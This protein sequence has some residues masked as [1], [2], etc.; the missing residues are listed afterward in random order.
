MQ[1]NLILLGGSLIQRYIVVSK[2]SIEEMIKHGGYYMNKSFNII[3][4]A[5]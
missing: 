2:I 5:C 4:G 1:F 3:Y